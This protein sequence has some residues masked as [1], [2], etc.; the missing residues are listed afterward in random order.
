MDMQNTAR[1][2]YKESNL[3]DLKVLSSTGF[4]ESDIESFKNIKGVDG[5]MLS[6]TLDVTTKVKDKEYVLKLHSINYNHGED[7]NDYIN[8]LILTDGKYPSTLNEGLVEEAFLKDNNL[9][10]GDLVTLKPE[11]NNDLRAKKIKI[12]GTVKNSYY[13]SK[14]RGSSTL[15]NGKVNYYMYL[16][17]NNFN[18]DYYT[19]S[20][21]T[22]DGAKKYNT[23]SNKYKEHINK[24]ENE[25]LKVT[26]SNTNKKYDEQV[27]SLKSNIEVLERNLNELHTSQ[28]PH[29]FINE[30][31]KNLSG[32]LEIAKNTL[33]KIKSPTSY[34]LTRNEIP[35]FYEYKLETERIKNIAK[36][37][38][39]IFFLVAAL[40]SL[41]AMTR[42]VEEERSELGT[43]EAIG[44]SKFDISFK[45]ILYAFLA[46][47]IG[48]L[49]GSILFYKF[50][51]KIVAMCYG[52]F[53]EMPK[54]ITTFQFNHV[55]FA[56]LFA[57]LSTISATIFVLIKYMMETPANLMRPKA[58]EPG[59]RVLLEK[60]DVIWKKL[61]FSNKVTVRNIFRYKKRLLMTVIGI[62]GCT[63][64]LLTAFGLRDSITGI[65]NKQFEE[66][67]KYDMTLTLDNKATDENIKKLENKL[68]NNKNIK[69]VT[70]TYQSTIKIANKK[71]SE[72]SYLVV[73]ESINNIDKFIKLENRKDK[74]KLKLNNKGIIISEKLSN[75]F[76][77]KNGDKITLIINDKKV[78]A[79][80]IGITENYIEHY[81]YMTP[82]LYSKLSGNKI[83]YNSIITNNKRLSK[84]KEDALF[85]EVTNNNFVITCNLTSRAKETYKNN[86][87]TLTYVVFILVFAAAS[88]A[89]VVLYNLSSINISERKRELATI[90]VLGFYDNEVTNYVHKETV[91][92]TILGALLGLIF[93]SFLTYYVVKACETNFLMFSFNIKFISYLISFIITIIF[94]LIVNFFM[95]FELKKLDMIEALKSV[96]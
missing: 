75:L 25:I 38:P 78:N 37:F 4:N 91:I 86:M 53:Y 44:Y 42:L 15:G 31:I 8:R 29:D 11:N 20:Y 74:E 79:K 33:N 13:A 60:M 30:S 27:N 57:L 52:I 64:L 56:S 50:I 22:I 40:V 82:T 26:T 51:P 1:N 23:Y 35:S 61:N 67:N 92:L 83:K 49:L 9:V 48:S 80:V 14:D 45:Y 72:T 41:T 69:N 17:E 43:L 63:G 6:K 96:E 70:K 68:S 94:L 47:F 39:L 16:E 55:F 59:K 19:E 81:V 71:K 73:P 89:F 77:I 7:N 76:N 28:L 34:V 93:G 66:I 62:C 87:T 3:M 12:V 95:H 88:L 58:P 65:V 85:K 90:K 10:I 84:N 24:Y 21:I 2:Y 32:Q 36:V 18:T 46:T 5:V 54:L